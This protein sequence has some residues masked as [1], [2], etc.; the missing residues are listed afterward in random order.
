VQNTKA[1][2]VA[3]AGQLI[4]KELRDFGSVLRIAEAAF[5]DKCEVLQ[6][7]EQVAAAGANDIRLRA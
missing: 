7:V 6:P 2:V 5:L 1:V 3:V 4:E